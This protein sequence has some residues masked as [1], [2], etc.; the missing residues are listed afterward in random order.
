[1]TAAEASAA[2]ERSHVAPALVEA[3]EEALGDG[4]SC[5]LDPTVPAAVW[6]AALA[7]PAATFLTRPGKDLRARLVRAGWVLAGRAAAELPERLARVIEI[8]HAGSLI[9]D[10]VQDAAV[11]RRGG[12]ALHRLVGEALAINTG[13]W[14]YF[15]ALSEL[16]ELAIPG[17]VEAALA[18]LVRCHQGQALDLAARVD[19]LAMRDVPAVVAATTRLK[20]GALCRFATELGARAAGAAADAVARIG[21]FGERTGTALQMFD[22]LGS[23]GARRNKGREDLLQARPTWPWA[24]LAEQDDPFVWARLTHDLVCVGA[25][26]A[27]PEA[28]A[29]G[30]AERVYTT[31][32]ARATEMLEAALT[33]LGT[34]DE[35]RAIAA[36]LRAM[37]T[38]YG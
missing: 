24:W 22:D 13:S 25:G 29:D 15:W 30:L 8:L 21:G 6:R 26:L 4:G 7:G 28:L 31:G 16:A 14:M 2:L 32:K 10:D 27:Y 33:A 34:G 19:T 5:A 3:L 20:T 36:E 37:E 1:M 17:A 9:V 12:P 35:A 11:Q 38:M 18:T 23:I